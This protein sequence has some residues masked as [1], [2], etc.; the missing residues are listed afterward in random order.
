MKRKIT[1]MVMVVSFATMLAACGQ[2]TTKIKVV[3]E[4]GDPIE[5]AEV[6]IWYVNYRDEEM[7]VIKTDAQGRIED[8]GD[9]ELRINLSVTKEGYYETSYRKSE[10][11]SLSKDQD[12]DL[13]VPLRKRINPIPL[14]A[15]K[16]II[17]L[18]RKNDWIGYDLQVGDI[19]KPDGTGQRA[20]FFVKIDSLQVLPNGEIA[21]TNNIGKLFIKFPNK[22]EGMKYEHDLYIKQSEMPMP[23][24]APISGYQNSHERIEKAFY[25]ESFQR[26]SG[27]FLRV[28]VIENEQGDVEKVNYA[29]ISTDISFDPRET[30]WHVDDEGKPKLY[31]TI[32]FTYYFNPNVNDRN[33]EFDPERNLFKNLTRDE[34]VIKP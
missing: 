18:P 1:I 5:G 11:T 24:I 10:G 4:Q 34:Q 17:G 27:I 28:R 13:T 25:N 12:H 26:D 20:D 2:V 31:G 7:K 29:K 22:H 33:L 16:S 6:T 3:D 15:K 30:G 14:Y 9:P 21:P 23:S 32:S 19:V 8:T